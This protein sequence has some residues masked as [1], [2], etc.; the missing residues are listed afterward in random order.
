LRPAVLPGEELAVAVVK[1]G[2]EPGQG[3][4]YLDDGT[5]VV[6][7]DGRRKI[8]TTID[9]TV[10]SILHTSGGRM[11]FARPAASAPFAV[12]SGDEPAL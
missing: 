11:I 12:A 3:V 9:V 5:M 6:V 2:R 1:E 4:G 8:G 10:T 7:E